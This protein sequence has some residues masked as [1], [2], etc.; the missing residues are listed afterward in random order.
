MLHSVQVVDFI[1][2]VNFIKLILEDRKKK[3]ILRKYKT[4]DPFLQLKIGIVFIF[5]KLK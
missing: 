4:L 1:I 5:R 3:S 2:I